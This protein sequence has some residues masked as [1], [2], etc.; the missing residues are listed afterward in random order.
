MLSSFWGGSASSSKY[1][2]LSDV[3]GSTV[4][5]NYGI[6]LNFFNFGNNHRGHLLGKT[7]GAP[8][9][10]PLFLFLHRCLHVHESHATFELPLVLW[11]C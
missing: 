4:P 9:K 8:A 5:P 1:T 11:T 3:E 6:S 10:I 7:D 2:R